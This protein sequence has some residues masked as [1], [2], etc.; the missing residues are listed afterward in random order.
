MCRPWP[1][2]QRKTMNSAAQSLHA[3]LISF[4]YPW[5]EIIKD[6]PWWRSSRLYWHK[7][8][9]EALLTQHVCRM[10]FQPRIGES[11]SICLQASL[12][13]LKMGFQILRPVAAD[14][15]C[16]PGIVTD[17]NKFRKTY[18]RPSCLRDLHNKVIFLPVN[19][20]SLTARQANPI[21]LAFGEMVIMLQ[22][23][24]WPVWCRLWSR[25]EGDS[26]AF[27]AVELFFRWWK[28]IKIY[29]TAF[30]KK[31]LLEFAVYSIYSTCT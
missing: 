15:E 29:G 3:L 28:C 13:D 19:K 23:S 30:G 2:L 25:T 31:R 20:G 27:K 8:H 5:F 14:P 12:V 21:P 10:L 4:Y 24:W 22:R 1:K 6:K 9:S 11:L 26:L 7:S 18:L 16:S 17:F